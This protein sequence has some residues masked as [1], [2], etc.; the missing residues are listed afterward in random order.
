[1]QWCQTDEGLCKTSAQT[2]HHPNPPQAQSTVTSP[3]YTLTCFDK[4][5]CMLWAKFTMAFYGMLRVGKLTSLSTKTFNTLSTVTINNVM[6][7]KDQL[8]F[9]IKL[10]KTD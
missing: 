4:C 3:Q 5:M 9:I 1:M 10:S 2:Y 7:S 8:L 6:V